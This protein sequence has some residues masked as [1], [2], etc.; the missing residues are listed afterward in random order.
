MHG[1]RQG[2][3]RCGR[4]ALARSLKELLTLGFGS[5]VDGQPTASSCRW[6]LAAPLHLTPRLQDGAR[7][8]Q[9]PKQAS[10]TKRRSNTLSPLVQPFLRGS[11]RECLRIPEHHCTPRTHAEFAVHRL[12]VRTHCELAQLQPVGDLLGEVAQAD[13][14]HDLQFAIGQQGVDVGGGIG[15]LSLNRCV[16]QPSAST[17]ASRPSSRR[18]SR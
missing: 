8:R 7:F 17:A 1:E 13:Q 12:Q 9:C 11:S 14:L 5:P 10:N 3:K 18:L 4:R 2:P 15:L 6:Q 16:G